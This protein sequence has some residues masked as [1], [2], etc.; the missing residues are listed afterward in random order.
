VQVL[1]QAHVPPYL[2]D[3]QTSSRDISISAHSALA[4]V[5]YISYPCKLVIKEHL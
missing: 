3:T 2:S 1:I 4:H 5:T